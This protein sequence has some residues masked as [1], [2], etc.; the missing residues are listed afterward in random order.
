MLSLLKETVPRHGP[1]K[2]NRDV[3]KHLKGYE[4]HLWQFRKQ[5]RGKK[6]R[7]VFFED[8]DRVLVCTAAFAKADATPDLT[9]SLNCRDEYFR[10]KGKGQLKIDDL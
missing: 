3:C 4:G 1:Q 9:S 2:K 6:L 7:V 5:P 8:G 10:A